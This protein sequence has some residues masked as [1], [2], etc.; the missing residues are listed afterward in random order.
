[1]MYFVSFDFLHNPKFKSK[2]SKNKKGY[3]PIF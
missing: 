1:M 3:I 2:N